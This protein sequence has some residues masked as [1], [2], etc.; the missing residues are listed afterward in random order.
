MS[1]SSDLR[2]FETNIIAF[3]ESDDTYD[4]VETN[5]YRATNCKEYGCDY[6][7]RCSRIEDLSIE[8]VNYNTIMN[9][10]TQKIQDPIILYCIQQITYKSGIDVDSFEVVVCGGYYG[11]ELQNPIFNHKDKA[12]LIENYKK[13]LTMINSADQVKYILELEYGHIL[14]ALKKMNKVEI[15]NINPK[16]ISLGNEDYH[17]KINLMNLKK[18]KEYQG[19]YGVCIQNKNNLRLIDGYHRVTAALQSKSDKIDVI[20]FS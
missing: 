5:Y 4:F 6:I 10:V 11:E 1:I 13:L 20:V 8:S 3:E 14:P 2:N 19:I 16:E 7:C 9:Q 17:K 12:C 15:K 18:Y